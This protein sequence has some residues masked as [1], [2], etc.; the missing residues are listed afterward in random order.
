MS[1]SVIFFERTGG[2]PD[3]FIKSA[4]AADAEEMER[5]VAKNLAE[6][7]AMNAAIV[8]DQNKFTPID[9]NLAAAGDGHT[10]IFTV[11]FARTRLAA[12]QNLLLGQPTILPLN[13]PAT[14]LDP[15]LY[16]TKFAV[17]TEQ[18]SMDAVAAATIEKVLDQVA[19]TVGANA[20]AFAPFFAISGGAKGQRFMVGISALPSADIPQ[21]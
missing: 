18:D 19:G 2:V 6:I 10:F 17:G 12:V 13:P 7:V 16:I 4:Q 15:S 8:G 20:T 5:V 3:Y 9:A 14:F 21:T 1:L 11:T